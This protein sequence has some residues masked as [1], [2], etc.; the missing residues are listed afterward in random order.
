GA[1]VADRQARADGNRHTFGVHLLDEWQPAFGRQRLGE[2]FRCRVAT[3][4]QELVQGHAL[5]FMLGIDILQDVLCNEALADE[6][7]T[8][9]S[10]LRYAHQSQFQSRPCLWR[11]SPRRRSTLPGRKTGKK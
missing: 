1:R 9:S 4:Y 10:L 11:I 3:L 7:I 8:Q 6:D 5:V 2:S